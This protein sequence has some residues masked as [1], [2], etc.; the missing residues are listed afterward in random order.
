M[1]SLEVPGGGVL[2]CSL[3]Q[4]RP[5]PEQHMS[6]LVWSAGGLRYKN[7][8]MHDFGLDWIGLHAR[9]HLEVF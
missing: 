9:V 7:N 8:T 3:N 5:A 1:L 2:E 4:T 6:R